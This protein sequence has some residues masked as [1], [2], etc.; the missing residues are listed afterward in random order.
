M[1]PYP[2]SHLVDKFSDGSPGVPGVPLTIENEVASSSP[3]VDVIAR[4]QLSQ[5]NFGSVLLFVTSYYFSVRLGERAYGTLA[6]SSPF[7]LPS[8]VLLSSFLLA[9]KK[10]WPLIAGAVLPIRLVAGAPAGTPLWFLLFSSADEL[11]TVVFAAWLLHRVLR[12]GARLDT[13]SDYMF[14]LGIAAG[15]AP[16]LSAVIAAPGRHAIGDDAVAAAYRWF[17]GNALGQS[18]VTPTLLYWYRA[19]RE[20]LYPQLKELLVMSTGLMG[21]SLYAFLFGLGP[22]SPVYLYAPV[23]FIVWAALRLRPIGTATAISLLAFASML[24]AVEGIGLFSRGS[25][26]QNVLSLQLLL[27]V[28]SIPLLSLS[29]IIDEKKQVEETIQESE[30]RFRLVANTAPVMI[31]MSDVDKLCNYFNQGWLEFTGRSYN[32]ELGNGWAEGVHPDDLVR[33]LET[34]N[35]A[36]DRRELFQMEYRLRRNDGEYRWI[37]DQG[38]PRFNT[39]G[40]FA[41]YIGSCIDVTE[42]KLAEE[43]ISTVS[44]KLIEAQEQERMRIARE[45]HDDIN[46]RIALLA[47]NLQTLYQSPGASG[48]LRQSVGDAITELEELGIDVQSLSHRLHSSKLEYLGLASAAAG[49]CTEVSMRHEVEIDFHSE[50]IPKDIPRETS[51]CLFRVLQEGL[52]NAVKHSGSRE[53]QVSLRGTTS[54]IELTVHDSGIGFDPEQAMKG[55]GLG[56]TSIAERLKL[57]AG[58]LSIDSGPQHGTT[59]SARVLIASKVKSAAAG[60]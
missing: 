14:F 15:I 22:Y 55:P 25:A 48:Q 47:V 26:S 43:A 6:V 33:C 32:A 34:Y 29:I 60:F 24:G 30:E 12:R 2:F 52:Q 37:F 35:G 28:V 17:L 40:S 41:G 39:E 51:L 19:I 10:Y 59:L 54:E 56:L 53:F 31:W 16:A 38:V 3:H 5:I 49:F 11:L 44:H 23:P 27:L 7:W 21:V 13:L 20:G 1:K 46:Q 4:D 50:N 8:A 36:F 42:R 18:I 57:M 9:Q 45:L 58:E